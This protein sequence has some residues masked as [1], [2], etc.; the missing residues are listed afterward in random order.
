MP[1][2]RK[3]TVMPLMISLKQFDGPLDLLL[4]LIGKAKIDIKDIFVSEITEQYIQSFQ[5][6]VDLDLEDASAFLVMAATLIEIK[7]RAL[8]PRMPA[9]NEDEEDAEAA[10][11]RQ[12]EEYKRFRETT[13]HLQRF[14]EAAAGM[15]EKL[16]EEYPLPP[17]SL[18]LSGLSLEGL[19]AAIAEVYARKPDLSDEQD[20]AGRSIHRD[21]YTVKECMLHILTRLK[22]TKKVR[23]DAL[24][25]EAPC[26]EEVVTLFIA[27][28]EILKLGKAHIEQKSVYDTIFLLNGRSRKH[29]AG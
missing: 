9:G 8:L 14:E 20:S 1:E 15:Y 11:I 10:L 16:P 25:G 4:H 6:A 27:L 18:E 19:V 7:S 2:S 26:R 5:H 23:F 24:F 17:P 28:L 22:Q 3:D 21:I 13:A 29:A 12:L